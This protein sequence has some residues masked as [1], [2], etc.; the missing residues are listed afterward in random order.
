MK[1]II[2][3]QRIDYLSDRDE[4][5]ESIDVRLILFLKK[6][7]YTP[8]VISNFLQEDIEP[9][10]N[11]LNP[12]GII[13]SGGNNINDYADRD[14]TEKH[15]LEYAIRY[16][17]PVIGICRGLQ[18]MNHYLGGTL[19]RVINHIGNKHALSGLWP[20]MK[21]ID[22]V[23]SYHEFAIDQLGDGLEVLASYESIIEAVEHKKYQWL[24]IM[25]HPERES[26]FTDYDQ[27][28]FKEYLG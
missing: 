20:M 15:L 23:N 4:L 13:L 21:S 22:M 19:K 16:R 27:E 17:L 2:I 5:R 24:G 3:S 8:Y 14:R 26:V 7:G 12:I 9:W 6:L 1:N 28:I 18:Y 25:W 11:Q 10:L